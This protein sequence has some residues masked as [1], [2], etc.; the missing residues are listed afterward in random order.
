MTKRLPS[1]GGPSRRNHL[2]LRDEIAFHLYH[3]VPSYLQGAFRRRPMTTAV[4]AALDVNRRA[5]RLVERWRRRYGASNLRLRIFGSPALLLLEDEAI[6]HVL[7]RS[8]ETYADPALKRRGMSHFQPD[9]LTIS[10]GRQWRRRRQFNEEVLDAGVCVHRFADSMLGCVH[11]EVAAMLDN[12]TEVLAFKDIELLFER[13]MLQVIFGRSARDERGLVRDLDRLMAEANRGFLLKRSAVHRRFCSSL[14]RCLDRA[15]PASLSKAVE[16]LRAADD[17]RVESQ[18]THWMFALK[19][20]LSA[21]TAAALALIA[22]HPAIAEGLQQEL[23]EMVAG[24]APK[25]AACGQLRGCL[26]EAMR[27]WPTTPLILRQALKNDRL[28]QEAIT[29][30]TQVLIFNLFNHR[31]RQRHAH[32]DR[33]APE[34]WNQDELPPTLLHFSGGK[35]SCPGQQLARFI[36][37]AVLATLLTRQRFTLLRPRI[38]PGRPLPHSFNVFRLRLKR[39]LPSAFSSAGETGSRRESS[40]T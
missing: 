17:L 8:P 1:P 25:L 39:S 27:L 4:F 36:G 5:V 31:D 14:S 22:A 40:V 19:S 30:G 10:R 28:G 7:D 9:A 15:E 33:F 37:T 16:V 26:E 2:S 20:T 18:V 21:N 29:P 24:S 23:E 12:A 32:A 38:E 11:A 3:L 35:Q 6:R 34:I 13:I